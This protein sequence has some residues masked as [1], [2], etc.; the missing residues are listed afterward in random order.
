[1]TNEVNS[2]D[3]TLFT[4]EKYFRRLDQAERDIAEGKGTTFHNLD[5]MNKWLNEL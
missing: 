4:K 5:D 1:M 2:N 3:P